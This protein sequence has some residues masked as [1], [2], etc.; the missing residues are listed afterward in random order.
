MRHEIDTYIYREKSVSTMFLFFG[1]FVIFPS[2]A[3]VDLSLFVRSTEAERRPWHFGTLWESVGKSNLSTV[4]TYTY[5]G[6]FP[7][8][9][10]PA[11]LGVGPWSTWR[12]T[13][14]AMTLFLFEIR[15]TKFLPPGQFKLQRLATGLWYLLAI[16]LT[17]LLRNYPSR[18][19]RTD[20]KGAYNEVP[21]AFSYPCHIE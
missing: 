1:L 21:S 13:L 8:S 10:Q 17:F 4:S 9:K 5:L 20:Y 19:I 7:N 15:A 11:V 12:A 3:G 14:R 6:Q 18:C 16:E 2:S